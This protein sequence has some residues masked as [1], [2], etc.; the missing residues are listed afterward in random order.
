MKTVIAMLVAAAVAAVAVLAG[1]YLPERARLLEARTA[2]QQAEA[3]LAEARSLL[4]VHA[5]YDEVLDLLEETRDPAAHEKAMAQSTRFFDVIRVELGRTASA[6]A[7]AALT[8]V[9][10]RR[11]G[12]T[13]ALARRD[14]A[15]RAE[16]DEIRRTLHPLLRSPQAAGEAAAS[17][18]AE[19]PPVAAAPE[20]VTAVT[21]PVR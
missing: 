20:G 11:D 3:G 16:L 17:A 15:V 12:V 7:R 19:A 21:G 1:L 4:E 2:L 6:E 14:P 18:S 13:A 5:Q 8:E 10:G 9:L